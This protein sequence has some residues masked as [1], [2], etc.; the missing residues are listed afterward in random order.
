MNQMPTIISESTNLAFIQSAPTRPECC[1]K[2]LVANS[3]V[4][5]FHSLNPADLL[6]LLLHNDD[7]PKYLQTTLSAQH[8]R[9]DDA[10]PSGS[11]YREQTLERNVSVES[12]RSSISSQNEAV[13]SDEEFFAPFEIL[14]NPALDFILSQ[15]ENKL[16]IKSPV[17]QSDS[18]EV[19]DESAAAPSVNVAPSTSKSAEKTENEREKLDESMV[20]VPSG[21]TSRTHPKSRFKTVFSICC[22]IRCSGPKSTSNPGWNG[23]RTSSPS[24]RRP[25]RTNSRPPARNCAR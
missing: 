13:S 2:K 20:L 21:K 10:V 23:A 18:S 14:S 5:D 17:H 4:L 25:I 24:S 1:T 22:Q 6:K 15:A 11:S 3:D 8:G 12:G 16:C 9:M 7:A 19:C